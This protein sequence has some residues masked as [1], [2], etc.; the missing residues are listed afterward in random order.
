MN[1]GQI[2]S[3]LA[4]AAVSALI[5]GGLA[6]N[7][8]AVAVNPIK[9][10]ETTESRAAQRATAVAEI[11]QLEVLRAKHVE[12]VGQIDGAI[13]IRKDLITRIDRTK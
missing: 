12:T 4:G 5:V 13:A 6:F 8:P 11:S 10:E 3:G 1:K 7:T 9:V 2:A